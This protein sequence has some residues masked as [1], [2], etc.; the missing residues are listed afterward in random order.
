MV[1]PSRRLGPIRDVGRARSIDRRDRRGSF[2]VGK[3]TKSIS[4]LYECEV[5][6]GVVD[7]AGSCG[8]L[9]WESHLCE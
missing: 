2:E 3:R 6:S 1:E 5:V 4:W 7:A 9:G 8:V